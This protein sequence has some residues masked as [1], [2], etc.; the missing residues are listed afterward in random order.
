M[1]NLQPKVEGRGAVPQYKDKGETVGVKRKPVPK[2]RRLG[3]RRVNKEQDNVDYPQTKV[4]GRKGER[5]HNTKTKVEQR[6]RR[7]RYQCQR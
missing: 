1:D 4:E 2:E 5:C 6:W 7:S 3:Y